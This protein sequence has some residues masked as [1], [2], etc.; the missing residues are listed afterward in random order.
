MYK[1]I[2]S[3]ILKL[4]NIGFVEKEDNKEVLY[5]CHNKYGIIYFTDNGYRMNFINPQLKKENTN[6]SLFYYFNCDDLTDEVINFANKVV[7]N[8]LL[9]FEGENWKF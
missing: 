5:F 8:Q 7:K 4:K 6:Y 3:V 1:E 9:D 2:E